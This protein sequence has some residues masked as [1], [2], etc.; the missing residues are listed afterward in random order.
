MH[1]KQFDIY[2]FIPRALFCIVYPIVFDVVITDFNPYILGMCSW[3]HT[4]MM[5][6]SELACDNDD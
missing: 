6:T 5:P 3:K 2:N 1:L 4:H